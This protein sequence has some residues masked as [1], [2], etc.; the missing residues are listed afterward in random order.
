MIR[1]ANKYD[2][3]KIIELLKDFAIKSDNPLTKNPLSWSKTY[4]ESILNYLY[5]GRGFVL[6]DNKQTG[7]LVAVK[8]QCFWNEHIYQLQEVM[9]HGQTNIVIARLIKEYI[10]LG[11]EMIDK[12]EINQAVISSYSHVDLSKFGLKLLEHHWDI[13]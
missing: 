13:R 8:N 1:F 5:A 9:L 6:I 7:I 12:H 10:R 3:D 4:V 11:K 2:N